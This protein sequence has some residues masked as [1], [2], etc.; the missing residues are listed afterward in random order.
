LEVTD[1]IGCL[2]VS[3]ADAGP[4]VPITSVR[5]LVTVAG[6]ATSPTTAT[7]TSRAGNS[8]STA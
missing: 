4:S 6:S 7:I 3:T 5:N 2:K 1:S 8:E